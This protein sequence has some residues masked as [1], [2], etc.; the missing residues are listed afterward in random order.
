MQRSCQK[1]ES[2]LAN[3][4]PRA[5][6]PPH[7]PVMLNLDPLSRNLLCFPQKPV[8][9]AGIL[10]CSWSGQM[11]KN[12]AYP[13][14]PVRICSPR[15]FANCPRHEL[16]THR[17][18]MRMHLLRSDQLRTEWAKVDG[19]T[20][21]RSYWPLV[22]ERRMKAAEYGHRVHDIARFSQWTRSVIERRTSG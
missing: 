13:V 20:A 18:T 22:H 14:L 8:P 3:A 4:S 6:S 7:Q 12:W 11:L 9:R 1:A 19:R 15:I 17:P 16:R 5:L 10:F 2:V 21:G